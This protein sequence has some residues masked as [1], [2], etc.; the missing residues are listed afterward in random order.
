MYRDLLFNLVHQ[1]CSL[2]CQLLRVYWKWQLSP[3]G[4]WHCSNVL[5]NYVS[6]VVLSIT[7]RT[8][9]KSPARFDLFIFAKLYHYGHTPVGSLCLPAEPNPVLSHHI[10]LWLRCL[11]WPERPLSGMCFSPH[12]LSS[13][14]LVCYMCFPIISLSLCAWTGVF[15]LFGLATVMLEFLVVFNAIISV[16]EFQFIIC[17]LFSICVICTWFFFP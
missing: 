11:S 6:L 1:P 5:H 3:F 4:K 9:L 8:V 17:Y 12:R 15:C 7:E 2:F 16:V 13:V 10:C 14:M